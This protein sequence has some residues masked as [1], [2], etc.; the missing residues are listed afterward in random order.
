MFI[1]DNDPL[2]P[3]GG[4][5]TPESIYVNRRKWLRAAGFAV[6][7]GVIGGSG[8]LGWKAYRGSDEDVLEGGRVTAKEPA[9]QKSSLENATTEETAEEMNELTY[10]ERLL[11]HFPAKRDERFKYGRAETDRAEAA[12]YTNF[13]EFSTRKDSWRYVENFQPYPWEIQV[14]GLCRNEMK[15]DIADFHKIYKDEFIER[16]YRHRCVEA[17]AMAV[18]W[19]GVR[20]ASIIKAA[21]PLPEA[22]HVRFVTFMRPE[23]ALRQQYNDFPWPYVEGLTMPEATNELVLLATGIYGEPILKQ[24]G[25]PVRLVV[26]WKYGF[27]SIKSIQR[28]EFVNHE[29]KTFW[30]GY[31][32]D[33]Y[34]FESN[35]EPDIAYTRWPQNEE[36]MLG[37]NERFP[38]QLYNGYGS[39]VAELYA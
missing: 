6:G 11:S 19:T 12:R 8:Y 36:R 5:E 21:D 13:Y 14:D 39:Y 27:K 2:D 4:T 10:A 26:P 33:T 29:P 24:H 15:I 25:A 35:V 16:Q 30:T 38:T 23:Q 3:V 31:M 22:T 32:P 17:W 28:I 18:P 20:L 9:A 37:T 1:H 7:A 34:P